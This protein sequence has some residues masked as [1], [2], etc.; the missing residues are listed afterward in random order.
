MKKITI[1]LILL[2]LSHSSFAQDAESDF[3]NIDIYL[4]TVDVG[5]LVY[6]NFGHT[7]VRVHNKNTGTDEVYNWGIF[8]F[9]DPVEFS[10]NFY[11][12]VL[13]YKLGVYPYS[14]ALRHYKLENRT[15]WEDKLSLTT[16]Q[17]KSL[18]QRLSW[19]RSPENISYRY[20]YFFNNCSTMVRDYFD[21][22]LNGNLEKAYSPL[23]SGQKFRDKVQQGYATNPEVQL[24]L[25]ILMNANIDVEMTRW[26]QMFLPLNLRQE[27]INFEGGKLILSSRVILQAKT[28]KAFSLSSFQI[29]AIF[30][31]ILFF[32]IHMG[33]RRE[34]GFMLERLL[35]IPCFF[36]LLI[37][38]L[39]GFAM[40]LNWIL[41]DHIDLH[42]NANIL[43]LWPI[44]LYLLW[45]LFKIIKQGRKL[46]VE[47]KYKHKWDTFIFAHILGNILFFL[48]WL[49]G[50]FNQDV[51]NS[52]LYLMPCLSIMMIQ[53]R[54]SYNKTV[55]AA[56][57]SSGSSIINS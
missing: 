49:V 3:G 7:A 53:I 8:D 39:F 38:G 40:P 15:V 29:L 27:L 16:N 1:I 19:N 57:R 13:I 21:E 47:N 4:H 11:K 17:K 44:D 10:F 54:H 30:M 46:S 24:P 45:P 43:L 34:E 18:L 31:L 12:G 28:P 42:H 23:L 35:F 5:D 33:Q 37:L 25:D 22:A 6:N 48:M 52:A 2:F 32:G 36:I 50:L 41:S 56:V 55:S 26:Q 14:S 51:S 20:H 9:K